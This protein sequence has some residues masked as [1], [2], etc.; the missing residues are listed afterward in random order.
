MGTELIK[1]E[2]NFVLERND[3]E[4]FLRKILNRILILERI[5]KRN[6]MYRKNAPVH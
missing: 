4:L 6:G 2:I 1:A 5:E 3:N